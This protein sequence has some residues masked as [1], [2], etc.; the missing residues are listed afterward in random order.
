MAKAKPI[1]PANI[2][3][4]KHLKELGFGFWREIAFHTE[5]KWRFDYVLLDSLQDK[6]NNRIAIEIEGG[7]YTRGRHTRGAGYERDLD[8]YNTA[9]LMGWR[10]LRFSTGQVLRGE[11]KAFL[12]EWLA[13]QQGKD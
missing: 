8:K 2:L 10:V 12:S 5:R 6:A 9:T 7:I 4:E 13:E 11:A 3:L 1:R